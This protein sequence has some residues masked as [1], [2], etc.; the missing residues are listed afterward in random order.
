M[1]VEKQKC[2]ERM[3][4]VAHTF[5]TSTRDAGAG[6]FVNSKTVWSRQKGLGQPRLHSENCLKASKQTRNPWP[7]IKQRDLGIH[8]SE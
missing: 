3:G 1:I 7:D 2:K 8:S 5:S 6:K 4:V